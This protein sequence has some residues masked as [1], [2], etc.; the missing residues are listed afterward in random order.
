MQALVGARDASVQEQHKLVYTPLPTAGRLP[1]TV[2]TR[3]EP[4]LREQ[5]GVARLTCLD[6]VEDDVFEEGRLDLVIRGIEQANRSPLV[7]SRYERATDLLVP[8]RSRA[9]PFD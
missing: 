5:I 9:V 2:V 3:G 4:I 8:G 7:T 6:V 1:T